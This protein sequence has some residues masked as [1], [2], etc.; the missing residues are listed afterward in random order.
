[1]FRTSSCGIGKPP[2]K[3]WVF[4]SGQAIDAISFASLA[5]WTAISRVGTKAKAY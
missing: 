3:V 4:M 1:M 5:A 2:M